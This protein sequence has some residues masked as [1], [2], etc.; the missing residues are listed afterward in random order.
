MIDKMKDNM[1]VIGIYELIHRD[2]FGKII[3]KMIVENLIT[4]EG[5]DYVLDSSLN[6][7][8]SIAD[9][10]FAIFTTG[11]AAAGDTYAVPNRTE[12]ENYTQGLRQAWAEGASSGQSV[13]NASA[14]TI[15]ADTGGITITGIGVVGSPTGATDDDKKNDQACTDGVLLS[16]ADVSKT[17]ALDETL[18][19]TYTV[20]A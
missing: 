17:L 2:K 5:K 12:S 6:D 16:S 20:N 8:A 4:N 11:T 13:T 19:I 14:A 9:W 1:D 18:D 7:S 10:F 15:T 3:D